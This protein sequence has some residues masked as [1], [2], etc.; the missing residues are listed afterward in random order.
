M[1]IV[2]REIKN[3]REMRTFIHLPAKVHKNHKNWLPPIF[4]DEWKYFNPKKNKCF[5][6][7]DTKLLMAFK[8]GKAVG[9]IMGIINNRYNEHHGE[10]HA[11]FGYLE[12]WNDQ[13]V[14]HALIS[15]IEQ[16]AKSFNMIKLI[17]PYGFSDKDP[18]GFLIEG[19][20]HKPLMVSASNP[21]Y[22]IRL[23]EN[24]GFTKEIDCL[25][26]KFALSKPLPDIYFRVA[27]R[28]QGNSAYTLHEFT[29]KKHLEPYLIPSL[30]IMNEAFEDIYGFD[31][32]EER[33]M[34]ELA[35]RYMPVL[36]PSFVKAISVNNQVIAFM[37][38]LPNLTPGLQKARGRLFPFGLFQLLKA[39]KETKQLDLMLGG[40]DKKYRG[41]GL[42][43]L[44]ATKLIET[45]KK[46]G[47]EVIEI[48]LMLETNKQVLGEMVKAGATLTKRF[49]VFQKGLTG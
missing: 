33:E 44:M 6:Y 9:R 40:I 11:R 24:E 23:V 47:F 28:V 5:L 38:A 39:A 31:Q 4:I 27:K 17:G 32:M 45:A 10:K 7:S 15:S 41:L 14:A 42:D 30:K 46:K 1:D 35:K 22:M 19:F 26:Y 2:I 21:E 13:E 48:H 16:W 20:E 25:S 18:Q 36:D 29:D 43:A 12:C 3:R 34:M 49:R 37:V 8:H